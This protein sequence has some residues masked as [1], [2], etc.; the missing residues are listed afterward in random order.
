MP[1]TVFADVDDHLVSAT[2]ET[3][4]EAFAKAVEWQV[5]SKLT[6]VSISD[7]IGSYSIDGFSLILA[8]DS[9]GL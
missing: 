7:G 9:D 4:K 6:D 1:F 5:V 3:A 2:A 8:N